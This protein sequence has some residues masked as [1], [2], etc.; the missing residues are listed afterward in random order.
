MGDILGYGAKVAG[1]TV[2]ELADT[3]SLRRIYLRCRCCVGGR[4]SVFP[5]CNNPEINEVSQSFISVDNANDYGQSDCTLSTIS[6]S[7]LGTHGL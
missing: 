3:V 6:I 5:D 2:K 7:P 1:D 4:L